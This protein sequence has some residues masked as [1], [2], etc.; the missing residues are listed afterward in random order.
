MNQGTCIL[1]E[2]GAFLRDIKKVEAIECRYMN[3]TV[4]VA[5]RIS[6]PLFLVRRRSC[7]LPAEDL[8]IS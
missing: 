5:K 4:I 8:S 7:V 3:I 2:L 6:R 1:G